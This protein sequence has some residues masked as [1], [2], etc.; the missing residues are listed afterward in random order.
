ME[1]IKNFVIET[2][3]TIIT[4]I[5]I[6]FILTRFVMMGVQVQGTSMEPNLMPND[7]GLSFPIGKLFGINRFDLV[8]VK[9]DDGTLI[10]K[11]VIGLPNEKIKYES[12]QLY[13]NDELVKEDFI[14]GSGV[15][16]FEFSLKSDEYFVVGDNRPVSLDSRYTGPYNKDSI[17]SKG[18]FV[19]TPFENFGMKK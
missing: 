19:I 18:V 3:K 14:H 16:D 5:V 8:V 11:R 2:F 9:K 13:I 10:V 15:E 4:A 6:A 12:D 1:K 17:V 7:K